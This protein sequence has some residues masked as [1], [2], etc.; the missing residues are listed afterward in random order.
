MVSWCPV[1]TACQASSAGAPL[2][3]STTL[4]T[5]TP[6]IVEEY[7]RKRPRSAELHARAS[8]V[9]PNG[10]THDKRWLKPYPAYITEAHGGYKQDVDGNELIDFVMGHGALLLGHGHP[11]VTQAVARQVPVG[12]HLGGSHELEIEWAEAVARLMPSVE[13][14]RFTSSGTEAT[15]MAIRLARAHTSRPK[16]LKLHGHFH[17]WHDAVTKAQSPPYDGRSVP[18]VPKPVSDQTLS[19]PADIRAVEDALQRDPE[20][21]AL[22][23]EPSGA[24]YAAVPLPEGFLAAARELT[25]GHGALLLFDEVVTGF[26]WAPG[27]A[28]ERFGIRPDLTMLAKILAGGLSGGAVAGPNTVMD[29]LEHTEDATRDADR[30]VVHQ[31]TFNANPLSAAAGVACLRVV[32]NEAPGTIAHGLALRLR[33]GINKRLERLSVPGCAWGDSSICH[34][35]LGDEVSNRTTRDLLRPDLPP[36]VLK[37]KGSNRRLAWLLGLAMSNEGVD[38]FAGSAIVSAAH[39]VQDIDRTLDA[40]ER[41]VH[42]LQA[43]GE[44]RER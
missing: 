41:C 28:Q 13:K 18:G 37:T 6:S 33:I 27:G 25:S 36:E 20:I 31:G 38:L 8:R 21:A 1:T 29:L 11:A 4:A 12:S 5:S 34:V 19:V 40:F 23:L 9:L 22:I 43:E 30:R 35:L 16:L 26:R 17:G 2:K 39:T 42:R 44:V 32:T 14:V 15:Q 7:T 10:V 3:G 24:G